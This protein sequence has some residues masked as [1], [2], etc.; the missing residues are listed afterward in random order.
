MALYV[1]AAS[2][3]CASPNDTGTISG[4]V[5][6]PT[7]ATLSGVTVALTL[8]GQSSPRAISATRSDGTYTFGSVVIGTYSL[9]AELLGF[10]KV[11][12][13]EVE[14]TPRKLVVVDVTL[15]PFQKTSA[16]VKPP[17][18]K[19]EQPLDG[20]EFTDSPKL[21]PSEV[22][23]SVDPGGYSAPAQAE[24]ISSLLDG[25]AG[26]K[27]RPQAFSANPTLVDI[28]ELAKTE[29]ALR[30][31]VETDSG[32]FEAHYRLG[33]F[34]IRVNRL[35]DAIPYLGKAYRLNPSHFANAYNLALA[36]VGSRDYAAAQ[37]LIAAM[38][39][40]EDRA[41]LHSLLA[42]AEEK[43]GNRVEAVK[44]YERAAQLD[45]AEDHL[46][47]W[48]VELLLHRAVEPAAVIFRRGVERH[49]RSRK[50]WIGLGVAAYSGGRSDDA[51]RALSQAI[52]LNP[53]D[54]RP[55]LLLGK[56]YD[57][58][59]AEASDLHER[60]RRFAE[61]QPENPRALYYYA[62]SLWKGSAREN[63]QKDTER[64]E[65]MLKRAAELDPEFSDAPLHLGN[66]YADQGRNPEAIQVYQQAIDRQPDLADAH[67]RLA[68]ALART[69]EKGR[70]K[71]EFAIYETLHK[72]QAAEAERQNAEIRQ[73]LDA[74]KDK[75]VP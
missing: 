7:G 39:Q 53:S 12:R 72:Q 34:Y 14:V 21:R 62:M 42:E 4:A 47:D 32:N 6:D 8:K 57:I 67:Y 10:Q 41:E 61:L 70:A 23:G 44:E 74:I 71:Q 3:V 28:E 45:P 64:I 29:R 51:V 5:R 73:F 69:G 60:L 9:T 59:T 46:F 27:S 31:S 48:G 56:L 17:V 1:I 37:E 11:S 40:R 30:N 65:S 68:Q 19:P 63:P 15:V 75:P 43:L 35:A 25:A 36:Y 2:G 49:P 66:L 55:Y 26:L 16:A 58:S 24:R 18:G 54:P 52:D 13:E 38:I 22:S 20:F 50:L 33:E